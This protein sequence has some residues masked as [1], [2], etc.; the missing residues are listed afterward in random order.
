[1]S[2]ILFTS[3]SENFRKEAVEGFADFKIGHV[4]RTM[5]YADNLVLL[6]GEEAVLQGMTERLIDAVI[7]YGM[8]M[9]LGKTKVMRIS[10]QQSPVRSAKNTK[11]MRI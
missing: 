1:M 9:N 6:S 2:P 11:K 5:K 10:R 8:E 7:C 4:I 3:Y